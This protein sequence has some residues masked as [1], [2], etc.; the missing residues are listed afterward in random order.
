MHDGR[1][2][3]WCRSLEEIA[4]LSGLCTSGRRQKRDGGGGEGV[5][6]MVCEAGFLEVSWVSGARSK[7]K[8]RGRE[9]TEMKGRTLKRGSRGFGSVELGLGARSKM[10]S[11]EDAG[12]CVLADGMEL[13]AGLLC[14]YRVERCSVEIELCRFGHGQQK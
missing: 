7:M 11:G 10:E 9:G 1:G 8:S 2:Y 12:A 14:G 5:G 13:V 6:L 3:C 4:S